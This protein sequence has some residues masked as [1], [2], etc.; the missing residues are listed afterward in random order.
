M[1]FASAL[2]VCDVAPDGEMRAFMC[3]D[4]LCVVPADG[5]Q[6]RVIGA[7]LEDPEWSPDGDL[8]VGEHWSGPQDDT[9]DIV[10]HR[11]VGNGRLQ[12]IDAQEHSGVLRF[13]S[14]A[15]GGEAIVYSD[16]MSLFLVDRDGTDRVKLTSG[17]R[18][19]MPDWGPRSS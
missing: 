4:D 1:T 13:P 19:L 8:I 9:P 17:E 7:G 3:G 14:W 10:L 2:S 15:P 6:P 18:D 11:L 16:E 5:G 12:L